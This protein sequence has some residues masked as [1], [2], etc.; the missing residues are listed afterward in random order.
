L[1]KQVCI[2]LTRQD[3]A[4]YGGG[5]MAVGPCGVGRPGPPRSP[6]FRGTRQPGVDRQGRVVCIAIVAFD[7]IVP[8]PPGGVN[9]HH[10]SGSPES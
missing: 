1:T 7:L 2:R 6:T 8:L 5:A 10:V 4:T 9:A 3:G